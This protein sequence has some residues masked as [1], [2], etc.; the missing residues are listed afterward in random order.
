MSPYNSYFH[1][2]P[3]LARLT[4][5]DL[6]R[7]KRK[8]YVHRHQ[9]DSVRIARKEVPYHTDRSSLKK[10]KTWAGTGTNAVLVPFSNF[11]PRPAKTA[12]VFFFEIG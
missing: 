2:Y 3:L 1:V 10:L 9:H 7:V 5:N 8:E 4:Q 12:L 6:F 11:L